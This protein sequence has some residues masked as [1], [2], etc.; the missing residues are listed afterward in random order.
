MDKLTLELPKKKG[1]RRRNAEARENG[2]F[3]PAEKKID[4]SPEIEP[5]ETTLAEDW[6][7]LPPSFLSYYDH[8][9]SICHIKS[10]LYMFIFVI[11]LFS[12]FAIFCVP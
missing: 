12:I 8:M 7:L 6:S 11:N 4:D 9:L 2:A 10:V 5:R 3:L 1:D